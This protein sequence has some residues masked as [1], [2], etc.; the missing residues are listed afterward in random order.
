MRRRMRGGRDCCVAPTGKNA[1]RLG[2]QLLDVLSQEGS[3]ARRIG[4]YVAEFRAETVR[5]FYGLGQI[6]Q[7]D[8]RRCVRDHVLYSE[9]A[10]ILVAE[11]VGEA[12]DLVDGDLAGV[13]VL[14]QV[15]LDQH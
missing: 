11:L 6:D 2:R 7:D 13:R 9:S 5:C 10:G 4:R 8:E 14:F 15:G 3:G 1:G 12:V